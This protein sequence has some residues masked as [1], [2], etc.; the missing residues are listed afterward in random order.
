MRLKP[1]NNAEYWKT[2]WRKE[3]QEAYKFYREAEALAN[4]C[5]VWKVLVLL[6][7]MTLL[8]VLIMVY[9]TDKGLY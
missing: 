2:E 1:R 5:V 4:A 3:Y 6:L 8:G 7:S 9:L